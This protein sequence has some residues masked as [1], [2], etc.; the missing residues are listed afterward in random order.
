V[1]VAR[2]CSFGP[3]GTGKSFL[4]AVYENVLANKKIQVC[5]MT[6]RAACLAGLQQQLFIHGAGF[7]FAKGFLIEMQS[8]RL[9]E[10]KWRAVVNWENVEV[11]PTDETSMMSMQSSEVLDKVAPNPQRNPTLCLAESRLSSLGFLPTLPRVRITRKEL[12]KPRDRW[13]R[14]SS[15]TARW[16]NSDKFF[17]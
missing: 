7:N 14:V 5:A 13:R 4:K 17:D 3:G 15:K 8:N 10:A 16:A 12:S 11:L 2:I 9:G 1:A 6:G